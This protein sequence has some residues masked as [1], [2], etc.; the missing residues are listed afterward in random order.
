MGL[1]IRPVQCDDLPRITAIYNHAISHGTAS[2][3]IDTLNERQMSDRIGRLVDGGFPVIVAHG[4]NTVFGYA[5]AGA[6]RSRPAYR[7]TVEDSIYL[8][9]DVQGRGIGLALLNDLIGRAT[10]KGFRQMFAV[11][12]DSANRPSIRIHEKAGFTHVGVFRHAGYKFGRWL[13]TVHMQRPLGAGATTPPD[14]DAA[15]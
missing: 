5:Y 2:F 7:Y 9:A 8:G 3:E 10:R 4:D 1:I 6:Y 11:I 14:S 15:K 12:G 13:D